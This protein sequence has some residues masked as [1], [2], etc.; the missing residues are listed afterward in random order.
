MNIYES[1]N[2]SSVPQEHSKN[3][4][5]ERRRYGRPAEGHKFV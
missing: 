2:Y 4:E 3:Y 1:I 5:N